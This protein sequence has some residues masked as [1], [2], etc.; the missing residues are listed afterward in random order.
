MNTKSESIRLALSLVLFLTLSPL[1]SIGQRHESGKAINQK[2][3]GSD[4]GSMV[5][6]ENQNNARERRNTRSLENESRN[7]RNRMVPRPIDNHSARERSNRGYRPHE[8]G[9]HYGYSDHHRRTHPHSSFRRDRRY[10]YYHAHH[11]YSPNLYYKPFWVNNYYI[12]PMVRHIYLPDYNC[13]YDLYRGGYT[14]YGNGSWWFSFNLPIFLADAHWS[15]IRVITFN[16]DIDRP[17][18]YNQHHLASYSGRYRSYNDLASS[19]SAAVQIT[20][21]DSWEPTEEE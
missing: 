16:E 21:D 17:W 10:T 18:D 5:S 13:Y 6:R 14:W 11:H 12:K 3:R 20:S 19:T 8:R 4:R 9:N 1:V 2:E 15:T 7:S